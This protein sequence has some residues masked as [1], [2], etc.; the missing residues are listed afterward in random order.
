[1]A[2]QHPARLD[3]ERL[4]YRKEGPGSIP[5]ER[6]KLKDTDMPKDIMGKDFVVGQTVVHAQRSGNSGALYVRV[7]TGVGENSVF[8][9]SEERPGALGREVFTLDRIAIVED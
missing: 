7:V 5:G 4:L 8:L 2:A 6:S 9:R 3:A 1:M